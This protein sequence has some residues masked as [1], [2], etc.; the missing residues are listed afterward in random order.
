MTNEDDD[1]QA[2]RRAAF[3]AMN[4]L[5]TF[6]PLS[7]TVR[8]EIGTRSHPGTRCARNDDHYLVVHLSRQQQTMVTSLSAAEVP[9]QFEEH[10]YAMLVADGFGEGGAGSVASR[11]A[12]STIAHL[13]LPAGGHGSIGT[14]SEILER[15]EFFYKRADAAV[16][17]KSRTNPQMTA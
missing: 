13:A 3:A 6:R 1:D 5:D 15:A 10:G 14:A 12:L 9:A 11:V 16:F 4:D 2:S 17:A 7:A 8:V